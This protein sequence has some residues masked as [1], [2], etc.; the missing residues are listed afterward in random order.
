MVR[1]SGGAGVPSALPML[2]IDPLATAFLLVETLLD[3][4]AGVGGQVAQRRRHATAPAARSRAWVVA[5]AAGDGDRAAADLR[6]AADGVPGAAA[7]GLRSSRPRS[8]RGPR[9][10]AAAEDGGA[11]GGRRRADVPRA[12]ARMAR[13]PRARA[14][15]QAD[16]A[17]RLRL[18]A[19][20]AG[21]AVPPRHAARRIGRIMAALGDVPAARGHDRAGRRVADRARPRGRRRAQ[22]QQAPPGARGDLQ[23][24][25]AAGAARRAGG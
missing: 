11:G 16:N 24:R 20:R 5:T 2:P 12:R 7:D 19:R 17:A 14:A 1:S 18:D 15:R 23:L 6:R 13:A 8:S 21:D 10:S 4:R 22:R 25:A 9:R 3:R